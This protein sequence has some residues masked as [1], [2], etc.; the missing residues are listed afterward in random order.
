MGRLVQTIALGAALLALA[1]GVWKDYATLT[2]LRRV[3][4]AYLAAYL[5]A[6]VLILIA[7]AALGA[8]ADP[9]PPPDP[10]AGRRKRRP[11]R[12]RRTPAEADAAA[13]STDADGARAGTTA[14]PAPAPANPTPDAP[15]QE[16]MMEP[17]R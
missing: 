2:V 10:E 17:Q 9:P 11:A 4:V 8:V 6:G 7:R 12:R 13:G 5:V 15:S 1:T 16:P 14:P 3:L